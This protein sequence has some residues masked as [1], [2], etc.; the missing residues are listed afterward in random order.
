MSAPTVSR[1]RVPSLASFS[2]LAAILSTVKDGIKAPATSTEL[3]LHEDGI[4]YEEEEGEDH[5]SAVSTQLHLSTN[6]PDC[7]RRVTIEVPLWI[8]EAM[9]GAGSRQSNEAEESERREEWRTGVVSTAVACAIAVK[10]SPLPGLF[11]RAVQWFFIASIYLDARFHLHQRFVL[12]LGAIL[13]SFM[14]IEKEVGLFRNVGETLSVL[15][16]ASIKSTLAFARKDAAP[17]PRS[18]TTT[19]DDPP[20]SRRHSATKGSSNS[21]RRPSPQAHTSPKGATTS[22]HSRSHASSLPSSPVKSR[23]KLSPHMAS[24]D[25]R[26]HQPTLRRT[27]RSTSSLKSPGATT[28][29]FPSPSPSVY[30]AIVTPP[31]RSHGEPR[32]RSRSATGGSVEKELEQEAQRERE[33]AQ[34]R[35]RQR[36]QSNSWA[37]RAL[38]VGLSLSGLERT[39]STS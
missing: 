36:F 39:L 25:S 24:S 5:A 12:L 6:C 10:E 16:E 26:S 7:K 18:R 4:E 9:D 15:W 27:S 33:L 8:T 14:Q 23:N 31:S 17:S 21:F 28:V 38:A 30:S 11:L 1:S 37:G 20:R 13:E 29:P 19:H 2:S 3:V 34:A 22:A 32:R 35:E